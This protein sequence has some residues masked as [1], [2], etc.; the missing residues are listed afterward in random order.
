[1]ASKNK[2]GAAI[3]VGG[4]IGGIQAALDLA[5]LGY[6]TYLVEKKPSIGGVM[7]QL[8]KTFPTN[9]C[10]LCILAPKMV[11]VARH[12]NVE[13][14]TYSE[15]QEIS[16][17]AGNFDVK[18]L[19]KSRYV[20]IDKC[21]GCGA[22]SEKCPMKKIP[23]KFDE[24]MGNRPAIYI[25]FPQAVPR[26]ATIDAEKCLYLT[27]GSCQLCLKECEAEAIDFD[28]K[29][30][31]IELNVGAIILSLGATTF[32][33][34]ILFPYGYGKFKNVITSIQ[35][36]RILNAAGPSKGEVIRL[37]DGKHPKKILWI[38]CIGSRNVR[39]NR[40]YCSSVCCMYSIKQAVIAKEHDYNIDCKI[41]FIDM[42]TTGKGFEEYYLRA[43]KSGIKFLK[44]RISLI[45][46]DPES[47]SLITTYEDIET[48][49][50]KKEIFDLIVLSVGLT[51]SDYSI[52]L[53]KKLQIDLNNYN[54]CNT[55]VF[56]PLETN[57]SGIF[58]C[59]TYSGPKDIPETVAEASGAAGR[60]S[61]LLSTERNTLITTKEYPPEKS[62]ENQEPR[63]GA[64]ICH[65]GINIGNIVNVPEVVKFV[66]SLPY[67]VYAEGNL[68]ACSQD[69]QNKIKQ[70]INDYNLN[71]VV[72]A[73]CT[74]R[75]HEFLFQNTIREAG[76]NPYLFEF[77]NIREQCSWVHMNEPEKATEKAK[78]LL[79]MGVAK[80]RLLEPIYESIVDVANTGLVIG[81]G[82]AGMTAALELANQGYEVFLIEKEKELGGFVRHIHYLLE[83]DNPHKFLKNLI[84]QVKSHDK[85]KLFTNAKITDI[86]GFVGNFLIYVDVN[87]NTEQLETGIIIVATGGI[88]YKP[89]EFLYGQ[90]ESILTQHE[91]E[92]KIYANDVKAKNIVMIQ[93]VGSRNGENPNCSKIC[94]FSAIK[95]SLKLKEM[96]P[97][98]NIIILHKDIRTYGFKEDYYRKARV[99]GIIFIRY[100]KKHEPKVSLKENKLIVNVYDLL[101]N[102]EI[103][104]NPDL[105]VL[106][107]GLVPR[108]NKEL[109]QLLKVPL[110][111]NGFFLEAHV[112]LRPLDFASDGIF[113]CGTAQWPKSISETIIQAKGAAARAATI[114]SKDKMRITGVIAEINEVKCIGCGD[115]RDI[116]PYKA[117]DMVETE[118][119]FRA[120]RDAYNS[121]ISV[122]RRKSKVH[123]VVCK[124]CGTCVGIC[125]VGAITL[126]YFTNQ[127]LITMIKSYLG[128]VGV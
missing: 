90:H 64:F 72:I 34:S 113:L 22:C 20:D 84:S 80:A 126:K 38:N 24:G 65:C 2:I 53:S 127:Q 112:K 70:I 124:G 1:M 42:R 94:C 83:G 101:L 14:L 56:T 67:I 76:L 81:G 92:Q 66:K 9:D 79:A 86:E 61:S 57:K 29:D 44:G 41:F 122:T 108:E 117:I 36:E 13:L 46:E 98:S 105:I 123:T 121:S 73:S 125:P 87:G 71:R 78:E 27:K 104:I 89:K 7:S 74:P 23:S 69:S 63:I 58:V 16:G 77:V 6:K 59:G 91:L 33:P 12:P 96:D 128:L 62:V 28:M 115:C 93:C 75:T 60:V 99:K 51:P 111:Q 118:L 106:S 25:P 88:E 103:T 49:G 68:F 50:F 21:T 32:D 109:S 3:V 17:E 19:K 43:E 52:D 39:I 54:F 120:V 5:E 95:N 30:E 107:A 37:S 116:C 45:K 100:N 102:D 40:G 18:I 85:I 26:K 82:V 11:E 114:L 35:F 8:D 119:K 15:I 110:D 97:H 31:E 4:G 48:G 47:K 55:G 10:S